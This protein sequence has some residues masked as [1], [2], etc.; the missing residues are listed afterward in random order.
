MARAL[1]DPRLRVVAV[2][3]DW[4]GS[5]LD[6]VSPVGGYE[7]WFVRAN[8]P[9]RPLAFWIRYTSFRPKGAAP[10]D[11]EGELWAIWFDG[12]RQTTAFAYAALPLA[13]CSFARN[14][15]DA[16]VGSATLRDGALAGEAR[17]AAHIAWELAFEHRQPPLLL[18]PEKMYAGSFPRAKALVAAPLATYR[19]ALTVDGERHEID[20]WRGSQ[21]HNWGP[22]HTDRYV[23]AQVAG[24]DGAPD[25]FLECATARLRIAG[26]LT[27]PLSV[28]V[29]RIDGRELRLNT[30]LNML[31]ARAH[32]T[33]TRW[34][35]RVAGSGVRLSVAVQADE[36]RFAVVPY[37]NPPGGVKT[38]RNSKI[39][40]CEV[41]LEERDRP[42]RTLR[43][44]DR[45]AFELLS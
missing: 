32:S 12:E 4:N 42:A 11:G 39:A 20:G 29:L 38:C 40:S 14:G 17:G 19:G 31:R 22:Q 21:N 36:R 2:S 3:A 16:R 13:Q 1:V 18:F 25:V 5:R 37:R 41:V 33:E 23:W 6:L 28:A 8:H 15:L 24:F 43:T 45:A 27:P 9:S 10:G 30:P 7:S 26:V 35:L 44:A 34:D